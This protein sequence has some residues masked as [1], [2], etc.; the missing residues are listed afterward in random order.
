MSWFAYP[1]GARD[2]FTPETKRL[3]A[4][5]GV[6]LAFSFYGGFARYASWDALDVPRIHVGA[7]HGPELLQAMV[8]LPRLLARW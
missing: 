3:L 4:E 8:W 2:S 5:R 7:S 1:V 6:R